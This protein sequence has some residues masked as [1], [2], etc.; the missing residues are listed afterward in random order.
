MCISL[1]LLFK[2]NLCNIFKTLFSYTKELNPIILYVSII[3]KTLHLFKSIK[4][5]ICNI[6]SQFTCFTK[7]SS[8]LSSEGFGGWFDFPHPHLAIKQIICDLKLIF[9]HQW[10]S[11]VKL[12]FILLNMINAEIFSRLIF[13]LFL[14]QF[15]CGQLCLTNFS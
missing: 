8:Q 5:S 6:L 4:D 3:N 13:F 2:R 12:H 9:H 7:H 15:R 10:C 1:G 11:N 14:F